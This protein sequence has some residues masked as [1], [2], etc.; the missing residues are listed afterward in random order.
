MLAIGYRDTAT[1]WIEL[2]KLR[3]AVTVVDC[4]W[5]IM[6]IQSMDERLYRGFVDMANVRRRLSGFTPRDNSMRINKAEGINDHRLDRID[7]YCNESTIQSF[8]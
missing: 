4:N 2:F 1:S 7:D 8:K 5:V 3:L 6:S